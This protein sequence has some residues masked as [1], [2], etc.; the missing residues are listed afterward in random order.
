M[1]FLIVGQIT[2]IRKAHFNYFERYVRL[3]NNA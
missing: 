2:L 1:N 3:M